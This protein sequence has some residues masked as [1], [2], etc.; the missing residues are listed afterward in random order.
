MSRS[1]RKPWYK[2]GGKAYKQL[3]NRKIRS[4][5]KQRVREGK[6]PLPGRLLVNQYDVC[7]WRCRI[8]SDWNS[9]KEIDK[10]KRK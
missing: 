9:K 10:A 5:N 3:A 8:D 1:T 4:R 6:E 2:D 7:D